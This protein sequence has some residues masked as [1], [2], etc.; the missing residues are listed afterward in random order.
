MS[1]RLIAQDHRT[2]LWGASGDGGGEVWLGRNEKSPLAAKDICEWLVSLPSKFPPGSIF[3]MFAAGYDWTQLFRN[4]PYDKAWELWS[5]L[6]WSEKDMPTGAM[7]NRRRLMLWGN[8]GFRL[9]P[10][11]YLEIAKFRDPNKIKDE[12]GKYNFESKIKIYDSFGF[13][14]S[15]FI[16]AATG[17]G[18][19]FLQPGEL[20]IL[21]S[22]KSRR[23]E[24]T[25][26]PFE[27][28]RNYTRV[29]LR[30]LARMMTRMRLALKDLDLQLTAWHGA[31]C[32]AEAMMKKDRVA[33][34][35]PE[36]PGEMDLDD[37]SD[38]LALSLRAY[39]GGRMEMIKQG[40]YIFKFW[41]YDISSAHPHTLRN[42]L[43]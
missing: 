9:Y 37:L 42:C 8:Y 30:M 7:S 12:K 33:E 14:Q 17:F 6:P 4:M 3:V 24:F 31:G 15:A 19:D 5:G 40:T 25:E 38:P 2:F 11:K 36:M 27:E 26:I 10:S 35:Y 28:I 22:G 18:G 41:N 21:E 16:K 20:E 34:Y 13:F 1:N 29:E 23:G 32:I 43:T 39:I